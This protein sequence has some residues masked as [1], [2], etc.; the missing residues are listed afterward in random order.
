M[1]RADG[2]QLGRIEKL[3]YG[4]SAFTKGYSVNH[5]TNQHQKQNT[6]LENRAV[7]SNGSPSQKVVQV[8][9]H[10]NSKG[11]RSPYPRRASVEILELFENDE[12]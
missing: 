2:E 12:S 3:T 8:K 7:C 5:N 9:H 10:R 4:T 11:G 6:S 1:Y